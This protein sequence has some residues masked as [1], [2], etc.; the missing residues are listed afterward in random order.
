M[1]PVK[2]WD[3]DFSPTDFYTPE[4]PTNPPDEHPKHWGIMMCKPTI[5]I[6][7]IDKYSFKEK[8][9]SINFLD[10]IPVDLE[11]IEVNSQQESDLIITEALAVLENLLPRRCKIELKELEVE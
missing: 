11:G 8:S 2:L 5:V 4:P 10:F 1:T 9:I 7:G 6:T 3:E